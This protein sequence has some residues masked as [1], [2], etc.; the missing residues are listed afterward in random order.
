M[1]VDHSPHFSVRRVLTIACESSYNKWQWKLSYDLYQRGLY[2]QLFVEFLILGLIF[3]D[4]WIL[5]VSVSVLCQDSQYSAG[6]KQK[7]RI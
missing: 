3:P 1:I 5:Q 6:R 4:G 7:E 2:L